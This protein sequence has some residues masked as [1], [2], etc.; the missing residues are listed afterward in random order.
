LTYSK[1][2]W[3]SIELLKDPYIPI[4]IGATA[5]HY[6]QACFEGMKAFHCKDGAIRVFRPTENSKRLANS[7]ERI[8]MPVVPEELFIEAVK[9]VVADNAAYIPPYGSGCFFVQLIYVL[10]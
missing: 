7:C 4:H 10:L 5:L 2:K 6:G 3:G 8:C 1:G 9:T